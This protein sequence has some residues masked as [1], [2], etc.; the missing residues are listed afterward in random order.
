MDFPLRLTRAASTVWLTMAAVMLAVPD[1]AAQFSVQNVVLEVYTGSWC[2]YCPD[3]DLVRDGILDDHPGRVFAVDVHDADAMVTTDGDTIISFFSPAYPQATV[4]R[5]GAPISRGTWSSVVSSELQVAAYAAV[6][7][8]AEYDAF[9]GQLTGTVR[10]VFTGPLSGDLRFVVMV[11][12]DG[13]V[14]SGSGYDQVNYYNTTPGH[15][16]YGAGNPILGY[17]HNHVLRATPLGPFG[18][19]GVIPTTVAF[20][21]AYEQSFSYQVPLTI[22]PATL[23][24]VGAVAKYGSGISSREIVNAAEA[25]V[26]LSVIFASGFE[27]GTLGEWSSSVSRPE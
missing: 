3:G 25:E 22:D 21:S 2:G 20:G 17:V 10:T 23:S 24:V 27:L 11:V 26:T 15:P 5:S 14:G 19:P 7:V 8:A 12:E 18:S 1:A 9:T 13:V 6:A 4:N 16:L